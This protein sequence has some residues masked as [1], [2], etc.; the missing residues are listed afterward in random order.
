[1]WVLYKSAHLSSVVSRHVEPK[2][3]Y[4]DAWGAPG[5]IKTNGAIGGGGT[6]C[7]VSD[8]S[9]A[10]GELEAG[11]SYSSMLSS[12]TQAADFIKVLFP[13][14]QSAGLGSQVNIMCC[15]SEG[16]NNQMTMTAQL[17]SAGVESQVVVITSHSYT[18]SPDVPISTSRNVWGLRGAVSGYSVRI[19]RDLTV[20][21]QGKADLQR[22]H[23]RPSERLPVLGGRRDWRTTDSCLISIAGAT[24]MPSV[25]LWALA[26]WSRYVRPGAVRVATAFGSGSLLTSAFKNTDGTVSVQVITTA[27]AAQDV[28]F[29]VAGGT[30][31]SVAAFWVSC[32]WE[33][34]GLFYGYICVVGG[35]GRRVDE[36]GD[37]GDYYD[38]GWIDYG[39]NAGMN[40]N[41]DKPWNGQGW[42]GGTVCVSP[43]TCHALN[44]FKGNLHVHNLFWDL[45]Y[46]HVDIYG[47]GAPFIGDVAE[48]VLET[49]PDG[50]WTA[51][52]IHRK[53]GIDPGARS[54]RGWAC[55]SAMGSHRVSIIWEL[56]QGMVITSS[57]RT[58]ARLYW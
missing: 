12:G 1:M 40:Y 24:A 57:N 21:G 31:G 10:S 45:G 29:S 25:R 42:T 19:Q 30:F 11:A 9:C 46:F 23:Q 5:F 33:R 22:H 27:A 50:S 52:G 37:D 15:D 13:T 54:I 43:F 49:R 32:E 16:W 3:F 18:S 39:D 58:R 44:P 38:D 20:N 14:I 51:L 6:L 53:T 7:G 26:Q 28:T 47:F 41:A 36:C 8:A 35:D 48:T 2:A 56:Q 55:I 34:A 4:A 17:I